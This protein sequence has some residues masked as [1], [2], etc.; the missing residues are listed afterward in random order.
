MRVRCVL[1]FVA[2]IGILFFTANSSLGQGTAF[3]YQGR[4]D[5]GTNFANGNYDFRLLLYDSSTA[6]TLLAGPVTNI[7][8]TV[9]NGLF[10]MQVD[11]GPGVFTGGSNWLHLGVR[12]NSGGAF[13]A[14]SPRQQLTPTPYAIFAE[15]AYA[16]GL[17]GTIP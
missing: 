8:V 10:T 17:S 6:G 1:P 13:T 12:T 3:T 14:L 11:F 15:G 9:S 4:L 5:D 7:D 16:S 2:V